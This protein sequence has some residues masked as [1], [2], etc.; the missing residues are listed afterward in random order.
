[1]IFQMSLSKEYLGVGLKLETS[2]LIFFNGSAGVSNE[3]K[4]G[5]EL[6]IDHQNPYVTKLPSES[7]L[8]ARHYQRGG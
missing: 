2:R 7:L 3:A 4:D 5:Y 8:F 1:M 6:R